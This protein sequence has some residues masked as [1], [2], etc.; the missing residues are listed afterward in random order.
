MISKIR[1]LFSKPLGYTKVDEAII[2]FCEKHLDFIFVGIVSLIG[3]Y[4]RVRM[5]PFSHSDLTSYYFE[6]YDQLKADGGLVGLRNYCGDYNYPYPT[7]LALLGYLPLDKNIAIKTF[8]VMF[9]VVLATFA[10]LIAEMVYGLGNRDSRKKF[11]LGYSFT[12]LSPLVM[13][14]SSYWGQNDAIYVSFI[15]ISIYLLL[16]EKYFWSLFWY[17]VALAFKI[18]ALFVFPLFVLIYL[19]NKKFSVAYFVSIALGFIVPNLPGMIITGKGIMGCFTI[20]GQQIDEER[21]LTL[22]FPNIYYWFSAAHYDLYKVLGILF[23]LFIF[24][25]VCYYLY[26]N[27][28]MLDGDSIISL[29][30]WCVLTCVYFLPKM[31]ERYGYIAEVLC[32]VWILGHKKWSWYPVVMCTIILFCYFVILHGYYLYYFQNMAILN[33]ICYVL[34]SMKVIMEIDVFDKSKCI[35]E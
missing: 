31:H 17:G 10:G 35:K 12:F 27:R 33:I 16:K 1:R 4:M 25:I 22:N 19:I 7:V 15:L 6:W 3:L 13:L 8:T 24:V 32:L 30:M 28:I 20:Y 21:M 9:D 23:T 18:Q 34:F 14:N 5:F 11:V 2:G 26:R 29:G